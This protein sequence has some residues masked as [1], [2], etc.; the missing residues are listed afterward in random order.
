VTITIDES[1]TQADA[2]ADLRER[3]AGLLAQQAALPVTDIL[4]DGTVGREPDPELGR[5]LTRVDAEI[6]ALAGS[7]ER[8]A[9]LEAA[10]VD[11]EASREQADE[12]ERAAAVFESASGSEATWAG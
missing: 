7:A 11:V 2:L 10:H 3:R 8:E 4:D 1:T 6:A 9:D 12:T 5:A